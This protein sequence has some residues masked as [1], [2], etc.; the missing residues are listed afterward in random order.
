[1]VENSE[2]APFKTSVFFSQFFCLVP[3]E[4]IVLLHL[5]QWD[6]DLQLQFLCVKKMQ[7][8]ESTNHVKL[9]LDILW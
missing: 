8:M 6:S 5:P 9:Y 1:M 7:V 4:R 2:F 3:G